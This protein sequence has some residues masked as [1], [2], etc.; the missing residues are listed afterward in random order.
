VASIY[1]VK[2]SSA[3]IAIWS[4]IIGSW[5]NTSRNPNNWCKNHHT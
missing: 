5:H 4:M 3:S 2:R 1:F